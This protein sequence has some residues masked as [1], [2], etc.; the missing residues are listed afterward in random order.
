MASEPSRNLD[1]GNRTS[2]RSATRTRLTG[3]TIVLRRWRVKFARLGTVGAERP[4][5]VADGRC[6]DLSGVTRDITGGFLANGGTEQAAAALAAGHLP[7][8]PN[9]EAL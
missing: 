9:A 2:I 7:E 1:V 8:I 5:V 6:Y 4:V 3:R